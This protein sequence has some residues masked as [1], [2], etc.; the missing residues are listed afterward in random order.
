MR[1][2]FWK[3]LVLSG[4]AISSAAVLVYSFGYD[5]I[6][7]EWLPAVYLLIAALGVFALGVTLKY[8]L[9]ALIEALV[10]YNHLPEEYK[11]AVRSLASDCAAVRRGEKRWCDVLRSRL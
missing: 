6:S 5:Y 7:I 8:I 2:K 11:K 3:A 10:G 9:E 4:L 1:S